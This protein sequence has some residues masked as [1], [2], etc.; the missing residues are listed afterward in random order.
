MIVIFKE[1]PKTI[2]TLLG[3][4][5][6][7]YS[8]KAKKTVS[9]EDICE[10]ILNEIEQETL[11]SRVNFLKK[12]RNQEYVR[13]RHMARALMKEFVVFM[14]LAQIGE[15]TGGCTHCQILASIKE[16]FNMMETNEKYE[17]VYYKIHKTIKKK[18]SL[19]NQ[20]LDPFE[21]FVTSILKKADKPNVT[22]E[23]IIELLESHLNI[24]EEQD[25][26]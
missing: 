7:Y 15:K 11:I 26:E 14:S 24:E 22:K 8:T 10:L 6:K 3:S 17:H 21:L 18:L 19:V 23:Q 1:D 5:I 2:K 13:I 4:R 9:D 20:P 16:H 12:D 25:Y